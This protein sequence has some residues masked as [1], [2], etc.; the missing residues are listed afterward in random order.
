MSKPTLT[1]S[2]SAI[3]TYEN[4]PYKYWATKVGKIVSDVNQDNQEGS[5]NHEAFE[6][7]VARNRALPDHLVRYSPVLDKL[8]KSAG[9]ILVEQQFALD[10]QFNP[11][12]F[13]DW[14]R[15]WVRAISDYLCLN[16][17]V[18]MMVDYKFGKPHKD[19][20]QNSLVAAVLFQT[21]PQLTTVRSAYWYCAWDKWVPFDFHRDGA[22]KI[23]NRFLPTVTK[24]TNAKLQDDWPKTPNPL[25]GW[26]PVGNCHHNTNP[27]LRSPE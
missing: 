10:M 4:C 18:A 23:W 13:K 21:Y 3:Q 15:A 14:N 12:G 17:Q 2:Y 9:E 20:D 8:R 6:H 16:G 5:D 11:C 26:C 24:M 27:K 19:P 25:C 7:Y 1:W 22:T